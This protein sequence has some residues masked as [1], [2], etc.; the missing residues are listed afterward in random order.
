MAIDVGKSG[1]NVTTNGELMNLLGS[2]EPGNAWAI[3]RLDGLQSHGTLPDGLAN[4]LPAI[5]WFSVSGRI[6]T[7]VRGVVR[8]EARDEQAATDLRDVVRGFLALAKLQA[9]TRPELQPLMQSLELSGTGK[10]VALS[11][12]IPGTVFDSLPP[13]Q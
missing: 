2:L 3:G 4:R 12:S 5:T 10:T 7:D 8:A 9:G 13:R 6:D 11:F 1:A